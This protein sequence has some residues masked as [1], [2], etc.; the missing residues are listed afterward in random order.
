L[1]FRQGLV[2]AFLD[3]NDEPVGVSSE[4]IFS[5][6]VCNKAELTETIDG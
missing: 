2:L 1:K 3:I 4:L 5:F 6:R